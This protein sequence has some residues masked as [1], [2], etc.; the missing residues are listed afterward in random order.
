[1]KVRNTLDLDAK[2]P[3]ICWRLENRVEK[4]CWL[5]QPVVSLS[6]KSQAMKVWNIDTRIC[7][8][9]L[10]GHLDDGPKA[11][12]EKKMVC[13]PCCPSHDFWCFCFD[14]LQPLKTL[15]IRRTLQV[16]ALLHLQL[17]QYSYVAVNIICN[18][19]IIQLLP[20]NIQFL[21]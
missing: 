13:C 12:D 11:P 5:V 3:V 16:A 14:P 15:D 10:G 7:E 18:I 9:V 20:G 8:Q 6:F 4:H 17:G 21:Q 19:Q 1:M 2:D